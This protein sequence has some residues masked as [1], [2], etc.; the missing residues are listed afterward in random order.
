MDNKGDFR[1]NVG[2]FSQYLSRRNFL[3]NTATGLASIAFSSL[4]KA[5][6]PFR[7]QIS[8]AQPN[9]MRSP[10]LKAKAK[11]VLLIFCSGGV[12]HVDTFDHKPLLAKL[13]GKPMPGAD[14]IVTQQGGQGNILKSPWAF[15]PR[16]ESG[17]LTS[18]L[19]P[20]IGQNNV[21]DMCFIHSMTS[22][23]SSHGQA[24][25]FM[26]T[27]NVL[28]GFPSVGAWFSYALGTFNQDLPAFVT[29]PDP[30]GVPQSSVNNWG[31]GYLPG[32][33]QATAF[34]AVKDMANLQSPWRMSPAKERGIRDYLEFVNHK[35]LDKNKGDTNLA[36]RIASYQLAARMQLAVPEITDLSDEPEYI[37]EMYGLNAEKGVNKA[38]DK[39]STAK[40]KA[41]FGKNC[42]LARRLLEKGVRFV[43]LVNGAYQAGG[44]GA[45]NWD[46]HSDLELFNNSI[47]GPILDQPISALLSDLKMRGMMDETLVVF[48]SEFGRMPTV[49]AKKK[50]G[51][52][53]NP[54][55]F[56]VW[57]SGA[58]V[59][60]PYSFGATDEFGYRAVKNVLSVH[61][62]HATIMHLLGF[63][64]E[65][66]TYYNNG[67]ERRLTDVHGKVIKEILA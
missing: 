14:K 36:A 47:H 61:D 43:Q 65:R 3:A 59:K 7:P 5:E 42:L 53:H 34:N 2:A 66:L 4:L 45:S 25:N 27:G 10:E 15:K 16:G 57:L 18:D 40:Y 64:H 19:L 35:H 29:I 32:V 8:A 63:D 54:D 51:R 13:D 46:T 50:A 26:S 38:K 30:R 11:Q 49:Q 22:K 56:T 58:G 20:L 23:S 60:A 37:R 67:F 9:A 44:E 39:F 1:L 31:S 12:S 52:D 24:E 41:A 6:E 28:N 17:K 21:D 62:F 48:C 33:F 55:G